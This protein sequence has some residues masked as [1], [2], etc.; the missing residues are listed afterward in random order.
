MH[1]LAHQD[2]KQQPAIAEEQVGRR[3]GCS[4]L[5]SERD[6]HSWPGLSLLGRAKG[7]SLAESAAR[8]TNQKRG[9]ARH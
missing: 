3:S 8:A 4:A 6:G 9:P 5:L 7:G 2:V 1:C